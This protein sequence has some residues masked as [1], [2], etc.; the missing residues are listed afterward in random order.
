M[1]TLPETLK[2][3]IAYLDGTG[4][5]GKVPEAKLPTIGIKVEDYD[6]GGLAAPVPI[7]TG[8]MEK[9]EAEVTFAEY[10][11]AVLGLLGR[12]DA[13]LT[14]RGAVEGDVLNS[15][16]SVIVSMRGL[17]T[18][19]DPG[20]WKKGSQAPLKVTAQLTY[21]KITIGAVTTVEID[22]LNMKRIIGGVDQLTAQRRALGL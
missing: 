2:N 4:Y 16:H 13:A 20:T 1:S 19:A 22:A 3:Y 15:A 5:A 10:A 21:L 18:K 14:L 9:M 11:E 7:D 12:T 6:A 8:T 17:F